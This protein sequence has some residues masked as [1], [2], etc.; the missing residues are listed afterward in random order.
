LALAAATAVAA[1]LPGPQAEA[2]PKKGG[3]LKYVVPAEPPSFDGH[4]ETT[5]ALIHPIAPFYSVLI[6]VNPDNPASTTDFRC[7]LCTEMPKP[8]DG[9]KTYTFK[10]R[11]GVK[12]SDGTTLDAHDIVATYKKIISPPEGVASAR[13]A[14][15]VMVDSVTAPDDHTVVFKLKY[16]SGAFIPALANPYNFIYSADILKKDMHW[17]EKN[18]MGSGP[19][20]FE[21][22][23]AG[24]FIKGKR[25]PNY[26]HKGKPYLD[27]FEA[28]FADKQSVR[29]QAIQGDRAAIEFRGFPPK[30]RDDLVKALGDKITVQESDW[31]CVLIIT[32]N[33]HKKPF[34][35]VR[36][37]RALTLAV[38]RWGG[39]KYL[40]NIAIVKAVGGVVFPGHPL[41]A[42]KEELQQIA[43]YWPDIEKSRAEAKRLL[44]E[45]GQENLKF[46]L[47]NRGVDQPYKIVGTWLIDQWKKIG[48]T[49]DQRVQ[50]TGPFYNTLRSKKDF[51]VSMDFNC[52]AVVNPLLDVAKFI[53]D[54]VTGNQN[55]GY[56][57][58]ELDK[59]FEAMNRSGDEKEQ[60]AIMRKFEKRTLDEQAQQF[61]TLW[62]NRIIPHRSYV[63]GWKISPSHYLNQD[64]SGVWLDKA[65]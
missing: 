14:F 29:V 39:S 47:H 22:R 58:R 7:D 35:D 52:Q 26:Y 44:K 17:Y 56:Q 8:T 40:S 5:F 54:D 16:P 34:D 25:N 49:V 41:A 19:F 55:A 2:A 43:G 24:A 27:G 9:G 57:D 1:G 37:R 62:W 38:D 59:M 10:I 18:I 32:P 33:H 15:Y 45:A 3:I 51:D 36:V 48:L 46:T 42:T 30:S 23:Q 4:R 28:I 11:D 31:N 65:S 12:F 13:R 21:E 20:L 50:P 60:R 64:L 63:K 6:R 53:S 61:V